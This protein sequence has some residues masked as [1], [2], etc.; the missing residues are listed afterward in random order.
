[1]SSDNDPTSTL[2]KTHD[3]IRVILTNLDKDLAA[4]VVLSAVS[5][6]YQNVVEKATA[7]SDVMYLRE[8]LGS[9]AREENLAEDEV[10]GNPNAVEIRLHLRT[11][12]YKF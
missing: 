10:P 2:K 7:C 1:M 5:L 12:G 3:T 8:M 9:L 6:K 11:F 4:Q